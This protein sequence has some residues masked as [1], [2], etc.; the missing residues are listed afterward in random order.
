MVHTTGNQ[1]CRT[2]LGDSK[3]VVRISYGEP[4]V[5]G[6]MEHIPVRFGDE[7]KGKLVHRR[8]RW[9]LKEEQVRQK[10]TVVMKSTTVFQTG[11]TQTP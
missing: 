9:D 5:V 1:E 10:T 4:T 8:E 6:E 7:D 3:G 11:L 2:F